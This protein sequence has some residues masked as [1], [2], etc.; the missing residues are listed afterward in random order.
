MTALQT[1]ALYYDAWRNKHGDFS[2][3]PLADDF[4]F[5]K[6]GSELRQRRGI[7]GR[8]F[9]LDTKTGRCG[10]AVPKTEAAKNRYYDLPEELVGQFQPENI[11]EKIESGAASAI[12]RLERQEALDE[13]NLAWL[14]YFSALQTN[15]TP[16]D[17][18]EARY[19]DEVMA[20]EFEQLR[21]SATDQAVAYLQANDSALTTEEAEGSVNGSSTIS[22]PDGSGWNQHARS[23]KH[24]PWSE[25]SVG[26][27]RLAAHPSG[28]GEQAPLFRESLQGRQPEVAEV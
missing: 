6:T 25:R 3:V 17:R 14:A 5:T 28:D 2:E 21:F 18:A 12:Q 20:R 9:R 1:V 16:A 19:L 13:A 8:I 11:L 4:E 27:P 22:K 26:R 10:P 15:R 7:P 23:R 24:V